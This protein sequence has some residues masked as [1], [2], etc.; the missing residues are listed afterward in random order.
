[1]KK[2]LAILLTALC[3]SSCV[4]AGT[5]S[6]VER[7]VKEYRQ[8]DGFEV[9]SLGRFGLSLLKIAAVASGEMDE[10]DQAILAQ[11][12]D[13]R[14]ITIVDFEGAAEA[15]KAEFAN[16]LE[17]MLGKME[18]IL[19]AKDSGETLSIYGVDNGNSIGDCVLYSRNGALICTRGSIDTD[20]LGEL[21]AM[22][23]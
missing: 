12:N 23:K 2:V 14:R 8:N 17:T 9:L 7:L 1:M 22:A 13:I 5:P 4:W 10:E 18:L 19:E 16:R 6:R 20:K 21:M 15:V 3:V 11:F